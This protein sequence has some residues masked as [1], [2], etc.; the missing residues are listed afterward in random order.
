MDR[1]T[2]P[3]KKFLFSCMCYSLMVHAGMTFLYNY[4]LYAVEPDVEC[5]AIDS[6]EEPVVAETVGATNVSDNFELILI[7]YCIIIS[8][9]DF[10][11]FLQFLK[12]VS[13]LSIWTTLESSLKVFRG[14]FSIVTY[15]MLNVFRL[16]HTG[17]V[18]AG[19]YLESGQ[20]ELEYV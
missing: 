2:K 19:S 17:R 13:R 20:D 7:F 4:F 16:R 1:Y 10:N 11:L 9:E 15:I 18:C 8:V 6:S 12:I 3:Q 14:P 5:Y